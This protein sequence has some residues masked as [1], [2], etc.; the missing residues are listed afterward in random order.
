[1]GGL[2]FFSKCS[3]VY[4]EF[5]GILFAQNRNASVG[6]VSLRRLWVV[7][8]NESSVSSIDWVPEGIGI[9]PFVFNIFV[10]EKVPG[11]FF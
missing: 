7:G 6:V 5:W 4:E 8:I 1:M 11:E 9:K 3:R 2:L 10:K